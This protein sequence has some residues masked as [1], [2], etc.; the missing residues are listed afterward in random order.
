MQDDD[1]TSDQA[2]RAADSSQYSQL[3][4]QEIASQD[5]ADQHAQRAQGCDQDCRRKRVGAEVADLADDH[6]DDSEPPYGI[7]EVGEAVAFK[8]MSLGGRVE[9]LFGDDEAGANAYCRADSQQEADV[10]VLHDWG[11]VVVNAQQV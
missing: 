3:F 6:G 11:C 2:D 9:A 1:H 8:A 5:R 4:S 10:F 7:L